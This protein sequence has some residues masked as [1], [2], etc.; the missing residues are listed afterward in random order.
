MS[1]KVHFLPIGELPEEYVIVGDGQYTVDLYRYIV[2]SEFQTPKAIYIREHNEL[3]PSDLQKDERELS[4]CK[5]S[6]LIL[7]TNAFQFE[8]LKRLGPLIGAEKRVCDLFMQKPSHNKNFPQYFWQ[9]RPTSS[10][11]LLITHYPEVVV[12]HYL[13]NFFGFLQKQGVKIF[14][15]HPLQD[16][17]DEWVVNAKAII[18]WNGS[19]S[20]FIEIRKKILALGRKITFAECGYFPQKEHFYFDKVGVNL[21]SQLKTDNL[22]WLNFSHQQRLERIKNTF[23]KDVVPFKGAQD[24]TLVVLQVP[25][26][27]NVQRHS[28]FKDGMQTFIDFVLNKYPDDNLLFKTHP[29]DR[30]CHSYD[31]GRAQK[32]D[33][34]ARSL[35]LGAR[36]VVG[37]NSAVLY[38][39]ALAGVEVDCYGDSL[40]NQANANQRAVLK[41]VIARQFSISKDTFDKMELNSF[42]W[43]VE[44]GLFDSI[45]TETGTNN[46]E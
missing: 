21:E 5:V 24:Y 20:E 30:L 13:K 3:L 36:R 11:L 10:F 19:T 35:V 40:L 2:E 33:E 37:I 46:K 23:F 44:D 7:G 4:H 9:K 6:C 12:E 8:M 39:A 28:R 18:I 16:V 31:F 22:D 32:V 34:D 1:H 17:K 38:E 15:R 45:Q 26:D 14:V 25:N 27:S 43:L 29:K 42:S 41:A